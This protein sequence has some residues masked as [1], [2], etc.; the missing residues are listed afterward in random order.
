MIE[1]QL[2][3]NDPQLLIDHCSD[4]SNYAGHTTVVVVTITASTAYGVCRRRAAG[5]GGKGGVKDRNGGG[6]WAVPSF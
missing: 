3:N 1:R 4:S 5:E 2:S 6:H